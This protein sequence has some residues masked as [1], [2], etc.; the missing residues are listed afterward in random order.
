[1]NIDFVRIQT[2][3]ILHFDLLD[4]LQERGPSMAKQTCLSVGPFAIRFFTTC[5]AYIRLL[6]KFR[7]Y[8]YVDIYRHA[9]RSIPIHLSSGL[10]SVM[11]HKI[12]SKHISGFDGIYRLFCTMYPICKC[13]IYYNVTW[14]WAR[15]TI[16]QNDLYLTSKLWHVF[17]V[18]NAYERYATF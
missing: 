2:T 18:W 5:K 16:F 9:W 3:L 17:K 10:F 13:V 12:P 6:R 1:M 15:Y 8:D 11:P 4:L 7:W 14:Y